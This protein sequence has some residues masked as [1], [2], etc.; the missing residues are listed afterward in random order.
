MNINKMKRIDKT[1]KVSTAVFW[2]IIIISVLLVY[3]ATK[4]SP[5]TQVINIFSDILKVLAGAL[6]GAIAGERKN[7]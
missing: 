2:L 1:M 3:L 5:N 4:N 6:A 7:E